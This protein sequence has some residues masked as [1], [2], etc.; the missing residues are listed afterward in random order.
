MANPA[1]FNIAS[2]QLLA[3][4]IPESDM[5]KQILD[6]FFGNGWDSLGASLMG[7][8]A[9]STFQ[10]G[11]NM[12]LALF[13]AINVVAMSI[14]S[15]LIMW[16]FMQGTIG[17]AHEGQFL[18]KK[19]HSVWAPF[20]SGVAITFIAP[21][22]GG[23]SALQ[24]V[25]LL[26]LG[27]SVN[28][29]NHLSNVGLNYVGNHGGQMTIE[30]PPTMDENAHD[31][32]KG[33]LKS[34]TI[35]YYQAYGLGQ[36]F[37]SG[38]ITTPVWSGEKEGFYK[39]YFRAPP[40]SGLKNED[41]GKIVIPCSLPNSSVC[42][43]RLSGI[44]NMIPVLLPVAKGIVTT[45]MTGVAGTKPS[46]YEIK[47]AVDQYNNAIGPVLGEIIKANDPE[48][49]EELQSFVTEAK[50][51]GW[52]SLGSYYWTL[53][54]HAETKHDVI[55]NLPQYFDGDLDKLATMTNLQLDVYL[56]GVE[57]LNN[58]YKTQAK[59][60]RANSDTWGVKQAFNDLSWYVFGN[61]GLHSLATGLSNGDP[62][63]N[64]S[65]IGH[66]IIAGCE[67]ALL[68]YFTITSTAIIADE[69]VNSVTGKIGDFFTGG[70]A[71]AIAG[72]TS[73][74]LQFFAPVI[75]LS[76]IPLFIFGITMAFYLPSLPFILWTSATVGWLL[77]VFE[78]MAAAP[79]WAVAHALPEGDGLAGQY[80]RTGYMMLFG[81]LVRPPLMV[82]GFL[83]SILLMTHIGQFVGKSFNVF[84]AGMSAEHIT[85]FV[86]LVCML[87]VIGGLLA[88][89][90]HKVFGLITHL[91]ENVTKWI[92]QQV[93]NLG[94][95]QDENKTRMVF[96]AAATKGEG[97]GSSAMAKTIKD[98][99]TPD[100][101]GDAG[102]LDHQSG[103]TGGKKEPVY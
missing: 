43:A 22:M 9:D 45:G 30:L 57:D 58:L 94:E 17:T 62:I 44:K 40:N 32:A 39:L 86:T 101:K 60:A 15:V 18:G 102:N 3:A 96:G 31:V 6:S 25:V 103:E 20:R 35:Q 71:G 56:Q 83:A 91:P 80:G 70:I 34:L 67:T 64:F 16:A 36:N 48:F 65:N 50:K 41:M 99:G 11:A 42:N 81:V 5:S 85:G 1:A 89:L 61:W 14:G 2:D 87:F 88:V 26:C 82:V 46:S 73:K 51:S 97:V 47:K 52:L 8:T 95:A 19:F 12:M 28:F 75:L 100:P 33:I 29:S 68:S 7:G 72:G 54:R 53:S 76:I 38:N 74:L 55:N 24:V 84:A 66:M 49:H 4:K 79:L 92:G 59:S 78:T 13:A 77:L 98:K 21:V 93:Q 90:S 37:P 10:G 27:L 69:A 23:L 63:E